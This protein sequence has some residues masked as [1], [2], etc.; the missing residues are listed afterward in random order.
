M[1]TVQDEILKMLLDGG[2]GDPEIGG[3]ISSK[4]VMPLT[5]T[6]NEVIRGSKV[7]LN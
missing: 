5:R 6:A 7:V 2:R 3:L 1:E 4:V